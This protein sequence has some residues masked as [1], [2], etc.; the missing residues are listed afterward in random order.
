MLQPK[1][2]KTV[3]YGLTQFHYGYR[4]EDPGRVPNVQVFVTHHRTILDRADAASFL[5][6]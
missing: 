1:D 6:P 2:D 3:H 4:P 5:G